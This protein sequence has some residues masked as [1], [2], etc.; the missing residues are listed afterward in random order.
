MFYMCW[1]IW[2]HLTRNPINI[3][4]A[5]FNIESYGYGY[6]VSPDGQFHHETRGPD[7]VVRTTEAID[8]LLKMNIMTIKDITNNK[9]YL[10]TWTRHTAA[11]VTSINPVY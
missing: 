4:N 3:A 5:L 11:M 6:N 10:K 7:G 8:L 9:Y 2:Q 1:A